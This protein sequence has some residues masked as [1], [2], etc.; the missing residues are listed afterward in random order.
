MDPGEPLRILIVEDNPDDAELA[1]RALRRE[2]L[3][4]A[5]RCADSR[6]AFCAALK[7]FQPDL[8][9]SD[10]SLPA[11][12]GMEALRL[13]LDHDDHIPCIIYTGST[14]EETAVACM[15]AGAADYVIKEHPA[16][17]PVSVRKALERMRT[18]AAKEE[19]EKALR[20]SEERYRAIF[21]SVVEGIYQSTP[22]GRYLSVNPGLARM[23]GYD[24]PEE[25]MAAVTD[26]A[27]QS[28]VRPEDRARALEILERDGELKNFI[29]ERRRKDGSTL[30][31]RNNARAIRNE[32]GKTLYYTGTTEDITERVRAE[33]TLKASEEKYRNI[34]ENAVEG[35]FQSSLDGRFFSVNPALARMYGYDTAE[36]FLESVTDAATQL[37]VNP[38]DRGRYLRV[39]LREGV[40]TNHVSRRK[41][42]DGTMIWVSV[43]ARIV[44]DAGGNLTYIEGTVENVTKRIAAEKRLQEALSRLQRA[45]RTTIQVLVA[46]V[47]TRDPYT[48]G[49][50]RRTAHL[51]RAMAREMGLPPDRIEGISTAGYI[52]DIGKIS[53]PSEILAKPTKLTPVEFALIK[54][55]ARKGFDILKDVDSPWPLAEMVHQHHERLD[56]SG[57]PRGL[58]GEA[59]CLEARIL[60]V[61][62]VVEAMASHRPYRPPL[63]VEAAL[64]EIAQYRSVRYDPA[65]VDACLTLFRHKGFSLDEESDFLP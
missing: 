63:G 2:G 16:R 38:D 62:D 6:E 45:F 30:W 4:F 52:H 40:A 20:A 5:S 3:R 47:E 41:R 65:A 7:E 56:G 8:I 60:A 48:A 32:Q 26:I 42:R 29:S 51:A 35:I 58:Q 55:H 43:N 37:F 27:R 33:T 36:E 13:A 21:Q 19:A 23:Y 10:Y 9:I 53:C 50:Q 64:E 59:L 15:K 39:L 44:R 54:D 49:H 18:R 24:A 57:Y 46:A 22:A 14:N 11:F 25:L 17:L 28:F 12:N 61:A 1:E 34:F 31:V